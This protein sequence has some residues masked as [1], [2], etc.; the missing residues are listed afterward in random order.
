VVKKDRSA[1]DD[2][3]RHAHTRIANAHRDV[4]AGEQVMAGCDGL[5]HPPV[6]RL[7]GDAASIRDERLIPVLTDWSPSFSGTTSIT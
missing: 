3:G 7:D 5:I 2:V 1:C 4:L 6:R